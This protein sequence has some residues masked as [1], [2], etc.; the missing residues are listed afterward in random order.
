MPTALRVG[1]YRFFFYAGD[2]GEPP[3][4]HAERDENQAKFWLAPVRLDRSKGFG[5][6]EIH[7][8]NRI[9]EENQELF[10]RAWNDYFND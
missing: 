10:L 8:I 3:H 4:V 9:V 5:R 6:S 1:G 7:Q 2:R